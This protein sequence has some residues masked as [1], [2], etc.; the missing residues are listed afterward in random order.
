MKIKNPNFTFSRENPSFCWGRS[1][2][3]NYVTLILSKTYALHA[4][5]V[6]TV[7]NRDSSD[8]ISR[9]VT[10]IITWRDARPSMQCGF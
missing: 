10:I 7:E 5:A 8:V 2:L 1:H 9:V 4:T 6:E 3:I